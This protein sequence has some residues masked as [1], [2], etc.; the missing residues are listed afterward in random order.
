MQRDVAVL[1]KHEDAS[2][3]SRRELAQQHLR[4][5]LLEVVL[6]GLLPGPTTP[7]GKEGHMLRLLVE[8]GCPRTSKHTRRSATKCFARDAKTL[9]DSIPEFAISV[10]RS[11]KQSIVP[12]QRTEELFEVGDGRR[13]VDFAVLTTSKSSSFSCPEGTPSLDASS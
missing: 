10:H 1:V 13:V 6:Q 7:P 8:V 9:H 5:H 2:V 3:R 4:C 11:R 12:S